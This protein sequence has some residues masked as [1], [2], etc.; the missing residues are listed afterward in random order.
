MPQ[1]GVIECRWTLG[2]STKIRTDFIVKHVFFVS[3]L[4]LIYP[5]LLNGGESNFKVALP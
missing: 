4:N 3:I 5:T 1:G 2:Q